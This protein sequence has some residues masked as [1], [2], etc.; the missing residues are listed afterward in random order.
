MTRLALSL[1]LLLGL[2]VPA[3][4]RAQDAGAANS[5][6]IAADIS[7]LGSFDYPVRTRAARLLRRAP[8]NDVVPALVAAV[9]DTHTDEYVRYRAFV[10]LTSFNA[11]AMPALVR[12]VLHDR[13]DRLRETA[14]KWLEQ[15]P[16]PQLTTTL[17]AALQ[18]EQAEFVRPALEGALAALGTDAQVQ[19]ALVAE[20]D[21]GLDVFRS[22]VIDALGRHHATYAVDAL[23]AIA[24]D[25]GPLQGDAILALGRI[26]GGAAK[27]VL[28]SLMATNEAA[29]T[30]QAAQCLAAADTCPSRIDALKA[31]A[32][33]TLVRAAVVQAAMSGLE[34]IAEAGHTEAIGA[35]LQ[36]SATPALHDGAAVM[37]GTVALR[38]PDPMLAWLGGLAGPAQM[39]ARDLMKEGFDSLEDDY[40]KEQF[41][42]AARAAYWKAPGNS[43]ARTAAASIIERLE[44]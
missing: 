3:L 40:A 33:G 25:D 6:T 23:T 22:A 30:L 20:V 38:E 15:H 43:P 11:A 24:R 32:T 12:D 36:L 31:T 2:I 21:R 10:L 14:Y 8:E 37:C 13:N 29:V 34:E 16:D 44:F 39:Q 27:G 42:A 19:R 5:A 26:G 41:F 1:L 7:S 17:L 35:I 4:A 9:R 18:T 28:E